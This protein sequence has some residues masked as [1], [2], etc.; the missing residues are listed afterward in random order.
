VKWRDLLTPGIPVPTPWPKDQFETMSKAFQARRARIRAEKQPES[1]MTALFREELEAET[2]LLSSAEHAG[3]VGV[4]QGANYDAKAFY[5][6]SVD[7]IMFTRN[8][9]PFCR[10]CQQALGAVIDRHTGKPSP[11]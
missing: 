6:P 10:V 9:V 4:F 1:A 11:D 2:K 3:K 7:C 8:K 5:R